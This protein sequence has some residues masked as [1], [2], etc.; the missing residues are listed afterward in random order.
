MSEEKQYTKE[1]HEIS[2]EC[3]SC[4]K[5][6]NTGGSKDGIAYYSCFDCKCQWAIT[7]DGRTL[8]SQETITTHDKYRLVREWYKEDTPPHVYRVKDGDETLGTWMDIGSGGKALDAIDFVTKP[9]LERIA[10]LEAALEANKRSSFIVWDTTIH[11]MRG[12][13]QSIHST[14]AHALKKAGGNE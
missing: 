3:P 10:E 11:E 12:K 6:N 5:R 2:P 8:I 1:G 14:A 7:E 9:L 13:L 4:H